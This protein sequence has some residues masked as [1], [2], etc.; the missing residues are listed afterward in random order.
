MEI[1]QTCRCVGSMLRAL[2]GSLVVLVDP[3]PALQEQII[4]S[5][6]T[7]GGRKTGHGLTSRPRKTAA[8]PFLNGLLR[9]FEYAVKSGAGLLI[10]TL[11]LR[12]ALLL[13]TRA[14]FLVFA[15]SW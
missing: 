14:A 12:Y 15:S 13:C 8:E 6:G 11:H 5:F 1:W 3:C 9:L 4:V 2:M 7:L 10:G